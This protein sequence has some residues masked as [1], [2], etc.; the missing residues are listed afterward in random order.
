MSEDRLLVPAAEAAKMLSMGRSTF[1]RMVGKKAL[2]QPVKLCGLTRWRVA[3][4]QRCID[5]LGNG[6]P[7][8]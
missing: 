6:L 1:W 2:P 3:D 5:S 8:S 7:S 4:L